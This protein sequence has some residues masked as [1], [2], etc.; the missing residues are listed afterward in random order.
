MSRNK[1]QYV[2]DINPNKQNKFIPITGQ[3][4]VAPKIL[5]EMDIGTIIIMNSI[6]ETEIKKLAFLNGFRGN[7][8]T[9]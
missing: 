2:I 4:I 5:Q 9:L 7:F 6:Y 8:I 3:K 1:C